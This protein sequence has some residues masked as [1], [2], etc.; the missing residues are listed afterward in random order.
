[1]PFFRHDDKCVCRMGQCGTVLQSLVLQ[2]GKG[3]G[4]SP[5]DTLPPSPL[6][7]SNAL[8]PPAL[9]ISIR[10]TGVWVGA[11]ILGGCLKP[12]PSQ[13]CIG[14]GRGYPPPGRPA[15]AQPLS[16]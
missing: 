5:L 10:G 11:L 8:T 14:R 4:G 16:P 7:S 9:Q 13:G 3:L 1:M 6:G 15:Y 2:F 12:P